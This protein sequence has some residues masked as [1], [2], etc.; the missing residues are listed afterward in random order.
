MS[1]V[2]ISMRVWLERNSS[3]HTAVHFHRFS[4]KLEP[5]L[6][7]ILLSQ[8][9]SLRLVDRNI[10]ALYFPK[11]EK[12][13]TFSISQTC[14]FALNCINTQCIQTTEPI[15][16]IFKTKWATRRADWTNPLNLSRCRGMINCWETLMA[17]L[18]WR[19]TKQPLQEQ[20]GH[21]ATA[22]CSSV[23]YC[24][25]L[26]KHVFNSLFKFRLLKS[27]HWISA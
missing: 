14:S 5:Y 18:S 7:I 12:L 4:L 10:I 13:S 3:S 21:T 16:T 27:L 2:N 19:P 22:W 9:C 24:L 6:Y 17:S 23:F 8:Q 20:R 11:T 1:F 26:R 15:N 25:C